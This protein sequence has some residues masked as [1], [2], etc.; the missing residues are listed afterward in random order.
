[1][2]ARAN[3]ATVVLTNSATQATMTA[4]PDPV[5]PGEFVQYAITVT[6]SSGS[7]GSYTVNAQ[8]P[9]HNTVPAGSTGQSGSCNGVGNGACPT[10]KTIRWSQVIG[11]GQSVTPQFA[12]LVD[13]TNPPPSGTLIRSTATANSSTSGATAAADVV[14]SA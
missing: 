9:S 7:L 8:V 2:N 13:T 4:A 1:M 11:A 3:A 10:G 5:R 14:A 12:A 6:N